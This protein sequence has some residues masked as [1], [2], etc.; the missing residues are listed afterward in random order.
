[1]LNIKM[2]KIW[3]S[4][5]A[6]KRLEGIISLKNVR[7]WNS[8]VIGEDSEDEGRRF[9][10]KD[11]EIKKVKRAVE[12][13]ERLLNKKTEKIF[14]PSFEKAFDWEIP[15]INVVEIIG[16]TR[17]INAFKNHVPKRS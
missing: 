5:I 14:F 6:L 11:L 16:M 1:M 10:R 2:P 7:N 17:H 3:F 15:V 12:T 4:E 9:E 8:S 13:A